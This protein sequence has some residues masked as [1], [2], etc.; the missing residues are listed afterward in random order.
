MSM[1]K[2]PSNYMQEEGVVVDTMGG[3]A[4]VETAQ[5]EACKSCGARGACQTM[6]GDKRRVIAAVNQ[7]GAQAGDRVMLAMARKG[8][9]GASF[10]VYMVPVFALLAGAL[11]GKKLGP[12]W[13]LGP[14]SGAVVLA[15]LAL[16]VAWLV[17]RRV[18]KRLAGRKELTVKVVRILQQ[19]ERDALE[20]NTACL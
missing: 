5:Q 9:L 10:L 3:L 19:G 17:L 20:S 6:G 2:L 8:V 16:L 18:S 13:G 14:Q 1:E 15:A 4:Q 12:A 11:A 7:V